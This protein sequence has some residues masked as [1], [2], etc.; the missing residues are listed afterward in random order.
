MEYRRQSSLLESLQRL[1]SKDIKTALDELTETKGFKM[2]WKAVKDFL[3]IALICCM[4]YV[5]S[6]ANG[7]IGKW[8]L[9]V[10]PHPMT[11]TLCQL[12][13]IA[14]YTPP[15]L[16]CLNIRPMTGV[17]WK[18]YLRYIVSLAV[19]K[20]ISS[21]C[22]HISIWKTEVS[23]AH[24]VKASIPIFTVV[25]SRI[26]TGTKYSL[27]TYASLVPIVAGV[28]IASI[29][30]IS[31]DMVGLGTALT[32]TAGFS[33]M[34]IYT[35]KI[36]EDV[37]I[38]TL[39]LLCTLGQL[40]AAMFLPIWLLYDLPKILERHQGENPNYEDDSS[41]LPLLVLLVVD[42]TFHWLQNI[43]AF[44]L[45]KIV[46]P[47]TYSVANVTKRIAVI[48]GSLVMMKNEVTLM[49]VLGMSAAIG[50]VGMYNIVK[51]HEKLAKETL[52]TQN[53]N[54][55]TSLWANGNLNANG[56]SDPRVKLVSPAEYFSNGYRR[57]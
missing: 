52:P 56:S 15:L 6:T 5:V 53:N 20:F 27:R 50:G 30:E 42:G 14:I 24:T 49:N 57:L 1:N 35:K 37:G 13:T 34:T 8:I 32:A 33:I 2:R 43:L 47:L 21:V 3:R 7:I 17:S 29:T 28:A 51:Y 9:N 54:K 10:F 4:W 45:M 55:T 40:S 44:T 23:Y 16:K 26:I 39:R 12:V 25:F 22:A 46:N 36:T 11:I 18:Y 31:F 38:H 41:T 48:S 19:F